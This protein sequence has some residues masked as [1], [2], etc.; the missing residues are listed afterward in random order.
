MRVLSG[1]RSIVFHLRHDILEWH[2]C[3][4]VKPMLGNG[5]VEEFL[6]QLAVPREINNDRSLVAVSVHDELDAFHEQLASSQG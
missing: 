1:T 5:Y 6:E 3:L 2:A 4:G